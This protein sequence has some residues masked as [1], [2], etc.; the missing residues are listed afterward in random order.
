M[1]SIWAGRPAD[2]ATV[3]SQN[4]LQ[5]GLKVAGS[6]HSPQST[7]TAWRLSLPLCGA[8]GLS[9][10]DG[11]EAIPLHRLD[12]TIIFSTDFFLCKHLSLFFPLP[13]I[14]C[15]TTHPHPHPTPRL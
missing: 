9:L 4:W 15:C 2:K 13:Y 6:H 10:A 3:H 1:N 8:T 5:G 11:M 14:G 7:A 12:L